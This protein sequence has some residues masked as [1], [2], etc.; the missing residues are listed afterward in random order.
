MNMMIFIIILSTLLPIHLFLIL[1]Q[2]MHIGWAMFLLYSFRSYPRLTL[3]YMYWFAYEDSFLPFIHVTSPVL[4]DLSE[5]CLYTHKVGFCLA[6][7]LK[8]AIAQCTFYSNWKYLYIL[9]P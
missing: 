5:V 8:Y 3:F 1:S 7:Q 6:K 4:S 2:D 9:L